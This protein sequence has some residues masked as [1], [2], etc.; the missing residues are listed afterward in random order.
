MEVYKTVLPELVTHRIGTSDAHTSWADHSQDQNIWCPHFLS[1][2]LRGSEHLVPTLP[3]PV[4]RRIG[5]YIPHAAAGEPRT[6]PE[7]AQ[8]YWPSE[9]HCL[10]LLQKQSTLSIHGFLFADSIFLIK[11]SRN[12]GIVTLNC[13]PSTWGVGLRQEDHHKFKASISYRV[14]LRRPCLK[15]KTRQKVIGENVCTEV[16]PFFLISELT[17]WATRDLPVST[18]PVQRSQACSSVP[19]FFLMWVLGSKFSPQTCAASTLPA[20]PSPQLL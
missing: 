4:T 5:R 11:Y 18:Y 12:P 9:N 1:R 16:V 10:G 20:E 19:S 7:C 14:S 3:E 13:N 8:S 15:N 17:D 2:S 6:W